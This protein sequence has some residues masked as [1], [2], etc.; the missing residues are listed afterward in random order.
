VSEPQIDALFILQ[1]LTCFLFSLGL[2]LY[3]RYKRRFKGSAVLYSLVAYAG[4]IALKYMVQIPTAKL[5]FDMFGAASAASALYIGVQTVVFE[6]GGAFLVAYY[7]FSRNKLESKDAEAYGIGLAF[8]E[9]GV[10]LGIIPM[11]GL[12]TIIMLL[13]SNFAPNISGT[14]YSLVINNQPG[15]FLSPAQALPLIAWGTLERVSSLFAHF[16]WGYLTLLAATLRKRRYFGI[17]LPMGLLDTLVPFAQ[18]FS[19]PLFEL[20][21]FAIAVGFLIVAFTVTWEV[22]RQINWKATV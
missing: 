21:V 4:A 2:V 7:A 5:V 13:S 1:P 3:W 19:V 8:W 22:R 11:I 15:L 20:L 16:S 10:L 17:A 6:V 12:L 18:N 9:N 14:I